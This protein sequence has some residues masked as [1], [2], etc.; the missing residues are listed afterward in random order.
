MPTAR[1]VRT[2]LPQA[3]TILVSPTASS[4]VTDSISPARRQTMRPKSPRAT[5]STAST[6]K[7]VAR[8]RSK[9]LGEPPYSVPAPAI[10]NAIYNAIGVRFTELPITMRSILDGLNKGPKA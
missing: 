10:A 6:P 1:A 5:S 7:R 4:S 9:G 2:M 8:M 3:S